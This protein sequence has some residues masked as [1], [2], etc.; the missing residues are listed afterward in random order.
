M[1]HQIRQRCLR[2]VQHAHAG[3]DH[4]GNIVRG[5]IGSHTNGNTGRAVNQQI[6]KTAGKHS[7]L[8]AA[9]I[10]VGIPVDGILIDVPEHFIG[11]LA[12]SG[13]GITVSC[14][15]VAVHVTEVAVAIHHHIAHREILRQADHSIVNRGV[16]VGVVLTQH[17]TDAGCGLLKRLIGSQTAFVHGVENAAVDRLEAV[18]H[19]G[20]RPAN[21]DAHGVFNI[22][23]LHFFNQVTLGDHLVG[24]TNILRFI[25]TVMLCQNASPP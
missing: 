1:L 25:I 12:H 17:I 22:G 15:R 6:G 3:I 21:D 23:A 16:A 7:G 13:L 18:T 4:L 20:Q 24:E 14:G 11:Q 2:I 9:F 19:I 5:N 8:L 10:E